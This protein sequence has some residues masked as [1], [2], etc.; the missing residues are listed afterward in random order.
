MS[1]RRLGVIAAAAWAISLICF[2]V[3]EFEP[4]FDLVVNSTLVA[5]HPGLRHVFELLRSASL[6][7]LGMLVPVGAMCGPLLG[8][9]ATL[10]FVVTWLFERLP[11]V[12]GKDPP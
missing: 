10:A 4:D 2:I 8:L 11:R 3:L 5:P 6:V 7:S 9:P 12:P 1:L